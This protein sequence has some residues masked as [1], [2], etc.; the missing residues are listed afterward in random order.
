[1]EDKNQAKETIEVDKDLWKRA[2]LALKEK[3]ERSEKTKDGLKKAKAEINE[4]GSRKSNRGNI[5]T[6]FGNPFLN[7]E[8]FDSQGKLTKSAA[9]LRRNANAKLCRLA[10]VNNPSLKAA[11]EIIIQLRA[12]KKKNVYVADYLNDRGYRTSTGKLWLPQGL[13]QFVRRFKKAISK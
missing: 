12:E 7:A 10:L 11:Y 4:K 1:M 6:S 2:M 5:I 13:T 3:N 9:E 8:R